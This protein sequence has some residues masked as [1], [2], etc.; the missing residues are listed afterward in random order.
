MGLDSCGY[1]RPFLGGST[2]GFGVSSKA[3]T[4]IYLSIFRSIALWI[5]RS[6]Y[7]SM[8]LSVYLSIPNSDVTHNGNEHPSFRVLL[9]ARILRMIDSPLPSLRFALD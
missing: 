1:A 3:K 5:Y 6:I 8:C 9:Y 4:F 7:L 2:L